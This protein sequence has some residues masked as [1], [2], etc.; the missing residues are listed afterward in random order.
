MIGRSV[1]GLPKATDI[2]W[3]SSEGGAKEGKRPRRTLAAFLTGAG[4]LVMGFSSLQAGIAAGIV[5][6]SSSPF[7]LILGH[8][9]NR[10]AA[11]DE[12]YSNANIVW[13]SLNPTPAR[14]RDSRVAAA[15]PAQGPVSLPRRSVCVRLCDGYFFPVGP[16]S[17]QSD[18]RNQEAA[19]SGL[20][21]DAPTQ[22]F[23]EPAGSDKIEDAVSL[24]GARYLSLPVAF[25]N[26]ATADNTCACHRR[27]G[28]A[29]PLRDD[30]TLRKGDSIMTTKGIMVFRGARRLPYVQND[31]ATLANASMSRDKRAVLAAIERATLPSLR[32]SNEAFLPLSKAAFLPPNKAAFLPPSK[33]KFAFA[34]PSSERSTPEAINKSI[35]FVEPKLSA[36][37]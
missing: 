10:N 7:A 31:F 12:G 9:Q 23:V 36:S 8:G 4:L 11:P 22:L 33:A 27:P 34:T 6:S 37:D 1:Q 18:L 29:F 17:R 13:S 24:S 14:Q 2:S 19:C 5:N 32:Q 35:R 21:P 28:E 15:G 3:L 20:C 16:L 26:R 30:F 25:R